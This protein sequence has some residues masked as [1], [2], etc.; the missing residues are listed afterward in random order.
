M[1]KYLAFLALCFLVL[2]FGIA[3]KAQD[4]YPSRPI[5][6]IIPL[7]PGTVN[8]V[9]AR[10]VSEPL[11]QELKTEILIEYKP[12]AGGAVGSDF[13]AKSR[14]DGYTLGSINSSALTNAPAI[15]ANLPYDPLKDFTP[16]ADVGGNPVML[17]VNAGSAWKTL[18][19][20]LGQANNIMQIW[21][22][23]GG[24][25]RAGKFRV[26]AVTAPV[27][28]TPEVPTFT[29]KGFSQVSLGVTFGFYG[30][31]NLPRDVVARLVP[32][33]ERASKNPATVVKLEKA[34]LEV[35]YTGPKELFERIKKDLAIS[36]EVAKKAGI[37]QD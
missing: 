28:E 1:K 24:H 6:I 16:L 23:V 7:G 36:R 34:G 2:G 32:A 37:S 21:S 30:P 22:T 9:V 4:K 19:D 31:A 29:S 5:K 20:F 12:G 15:T 17:V 11:A 27:K 18:E 8:D 35:A 13:V 3:A 33:L 14:P 26:L 10:T 25:V